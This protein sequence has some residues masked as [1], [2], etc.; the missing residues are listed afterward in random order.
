VTKDATIARILDQGF[1]TEGWHHNAHQHHYNLHKDH[2]NPVSSIK[3]LKG[4]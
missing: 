3:H 4:E 1:H 2:N